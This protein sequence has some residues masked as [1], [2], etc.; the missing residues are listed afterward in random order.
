M[1]LLLILIVLFL[2][3]ARV[4][5]GQPDKGR[6]SLRGLSSFFVVIPPV[7]DD[8]SQDGLNVAHLRNVVESSLTQAGIGISKEPKQKEGFANLVVLIDTIKT[9]GVYLFTV[10]V[11]VVQEVHLTR[12]PK[13]TAMP[14]QTWTAL[15]LGL[16]TPQRL[17]IID[18]PLKEKL[19]DFIKAFRA[20]NGG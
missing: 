7:N 4:L 1:R 17:D 3:P 13:M 14:A 6:E 5:V 2:L 16:T 18:E 20:A 19:G 10:S 9:Q 11:G 15:A 12:D 8:I